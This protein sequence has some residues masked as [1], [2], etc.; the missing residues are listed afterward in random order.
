MVIEGLW[1]RANIAEPVEGEA[2]DNDRDVGAIGSAVEV[3]ERITGISAYLILAL[4]GALL[5]RPSNTN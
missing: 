3:D 4:D 2:T 1:L 5:T